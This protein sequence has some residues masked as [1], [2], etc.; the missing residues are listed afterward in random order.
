RQHLEKIAAQAKDN[1]IEIAQ[2][3]LTLERYPQLREANLDQF[4]TL[5]EYQLTQGGNLTQEEWDAIFRRLTIAASQKDWFEIVAPV[6]KNVVELLHSTFPRA[7]RETLKEDFTKDGKAWAELTL[8]LLTGMQAQLSQLQASQGGV[9]TEELAQTLEKFQDLETQ[10]RG[11]LPQQQSLPVLKRT[12]KLKSV[13]LISY[14]ATKMI[15]NFFTLSFLF[16]V[17]LAGFSSLLIYQKRFEAGMAGAGASAVLAT[18]NP[19]KQEK[20]EK[21]GRK[22]L[23]SEADNR[24]FTRDTVEVII[25]AQCLA[26]RPLAPSETRQ[27]LSLLIEQ[28]I[29]ENLVEFEPVLSVEEKNQQLELEIA[30]LKQQLEGTKEIEYLRGQNQVIQDILKNPN[31]SNIFPP[32]KIDDNNQRTSGLPEQYLGYPSNIEVNYDGN[33]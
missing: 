16:T 24:K 30:L 21:E 8:R 1:W 18:A 22:I 14:L 10:L 12:R 19:K 11:S 3:E 20:E 4:L 31:H 17:L 9:D 13:E 2:Q 32:Q 26:E 15:K 29:S 28:D 23:F 25:F 33:E 5:D 27:L 6:R 7:L